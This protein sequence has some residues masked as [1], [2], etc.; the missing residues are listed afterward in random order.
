MREEGQ[1]GAGRLHFKG[2]GLSL[3]AFAKAKS[4]TYDPR[5]VK[6]QERLRASRTVSKYKKLKK[7]MEKGAPSVKVSRRAGQ[8]QP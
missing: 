4:S 2:K 3:D 8:G 7:R 5:I 6:E 1:K